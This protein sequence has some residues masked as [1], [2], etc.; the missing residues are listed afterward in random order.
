MAVQRDIPPELTLEESKTHPIDPEDQ[1]MFGTRRPRPASVGS[2]LLV[3]LVCF[4]MALAMAIY[5]A[6]THLD[7]WMRPKLL[8]N[9]SLKLRFAVFSKQL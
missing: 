3:V 6:E 8:A 5:F 7:L 1:S 2:H 4:L 9:H